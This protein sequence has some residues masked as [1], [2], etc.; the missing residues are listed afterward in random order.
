MRTFIIGAGASKAYNLSPTNCTMPIANDFFKTFQDLDISSD[1]RVLIG[2]IIN[3][4]KQDFNID[5]NDFFT[6][7]F[8][9]EDFHTHVE[10][11][12]LEQMK[13]DTVHNNIYYYKAYLQLIFLYTSIINEI[14]N[15]PCSEAHIKL[16]KSLNKEDSIITFNWDTLLDRALSEHTNWKTD[17]GYCLKP[18]KI[19]KDMWIEA[20]DSNN[21]FNKL[22]KLHG[23]TNWLTTYPRL[24]RKDLF[25][26]NQKIDNSSFYI[27][28]YTHTPYHCYDG[29]FEGPY[30]P[31]SYFYYPPNILDDI[32]L[33]EYENKVMFK[34]GVLNQ[35]ETQK[36]YE[37][38]FGVKLD[39]PERTGLEGG[40]ITMPLIIPPVKN[41]KYTLFANLF[42]EL[43][44]IAKQEIITAKEIIIIG[45]SFPKTDTKTILLFQEAFCKK[46]ELPKIVIVNPEPDEIIN[47]F[48]FTLGIPKSN[49]VVYKEYF[50]ENFEFDKLNI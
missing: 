45:Y 36:M 5:I 3:I 39:I 17:F 13:E 25:K 6:S 8:D 47:L 10:Q 35:P 41:K 44:E 1:L 27:Y 49:I 9:I 33:D 37:E 26:L 23:S 19:Y 7:L 11:K 30:E 48:E 40:V 50:N 32:A 20:E 2:D 34:A 42:L 14:Q 24:D 15:G 31:F 43:W 4:A 46:T 21:E 16:I 28:E 38:I 18:E 29:R 12:L 22:I